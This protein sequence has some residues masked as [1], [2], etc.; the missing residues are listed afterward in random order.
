MGDEFTG[1]ARLF[2]ISG[3]VCL[4]FGA[5]AGYVLGPGLVRRTLR[6]VRRLRR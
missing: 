6:L 1:I 2:L 3:T 4:L 5:T